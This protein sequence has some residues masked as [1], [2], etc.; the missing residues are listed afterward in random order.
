M[1]SQTVDVLPPGTS[2]PPPSDPTSRFAED[3]ALRDRLGRI[4]AGQEPPPTLATPPEVQQLLDHELAR[5]PD[6]S[7]S[8]RQRLLTDWSLQYHHGGNEVL[9][10]KSPQG[11]AV[12]ATGAEEVARV[13]QHLPPERRLEVL[14]QHP[15]PW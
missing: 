1:K 8:E 11:L 9:T 15:E 4:F 12:L 3:P 14:V 7:V 13:L 10:W 2:V 6:L 5:H